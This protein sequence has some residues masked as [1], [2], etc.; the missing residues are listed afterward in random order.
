MKWKSDQCNILIDPEH[1]SPFKKKGSDDPSQGFGSTEFKASVLNW[2]AWLEEKSLLFKDPCEHRLTWMHKMKPLQTNRFSRELT[3]PSDHC[4]WY[5][6]GK[7]HWFPEISRM[8]AGRVLTT[9]ARKTEANPYSNTHR[10]HCCPFIIIITVFH[11]TLY[12]KGSWSGWSWWMRSPSGTFKVIREW[13]PHVGYA[14]GCMLS[15]YVSF[16]SQD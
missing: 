15:R 4:W 11:K 9:N 12:I 14:S 5:H 8:A 3:W 2:K 10:S 7:E 16:H 1:K 13:I 6:I